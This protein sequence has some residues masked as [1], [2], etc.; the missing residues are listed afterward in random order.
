[1]L[2]VTV[3]VKRQNWPWRIQGER[4]NAWPITSRVEIL[5]AVGK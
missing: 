5:E 4:D 1:M 2:E 3:S